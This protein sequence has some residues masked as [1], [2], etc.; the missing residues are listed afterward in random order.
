MDARFDLSPDEESSTKQ[1][2]YRQ[3]FVTP[4]AT[5]PSDVSLEG[6]TAVVTGSNIGIG[7]ECASQLCDLGV[8][9]VI[10]AVRDEAKGESAKSRIAQDRNVPAG[11]LEVW[12]LDMAEYQSI[13]AFSK[14]AEAL[15]S[16]DILVLNAGIRRA[17]ETFNPST[18]YEDDIQ[19]NFLSTILLT[20]LLLPVMKSK[21]KGSEPGRITLV[22]S[23]SSRLAKLDERTRYPM[24]P[25]FKESQGE[26]FDSAEQYNKSKLLV[27]LTMLKLTELVPR[28]LA[29]INMATPGFCRGTGI[30]RD[31][32]SPLVAFIQS[33]I[34]R[35]FG[36]SPAAGARVIVNAAAKQGPES[37][38]H[39]IGDCMLKPMAGLVY[40]SEGRDL[41]ESLWEELMSEFAFVGARDIVR[42]LNN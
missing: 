34:T 42:D 2:L 8:A 38:G 13:T 5:S 20:L 6:K 27:Q 9:K 33:H 30:T 15:P 4:P 18:G 35:L 28:S 37:H 21:K 11:L 23:D 22:S 39:C 31:L 29:I 19:I 1:F 24:L 17:A 12:K 26:R 25:A 32:Y 3:L 16:L 7:L 36:R 14:R 40:T 10:L 41:S